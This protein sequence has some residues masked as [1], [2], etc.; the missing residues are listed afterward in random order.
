[1]NA[2]GDRRGPILLAAAS[3]SKRKSTTAH[4]PCAATAVTRGL[5]FAEEFLI[6]HRDLPGMRTRDMRDIGVVVGD[7]D[8]QLR[9]LAQELAELPDPFAQL[10]LAQPITEAA[11]NA[12]MATK[13]SISIAP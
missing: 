13:L 5:T 10:A 12:M 4:S 1:M 3:F 2:C 9:A 11:V 8:H 7:A 6:G